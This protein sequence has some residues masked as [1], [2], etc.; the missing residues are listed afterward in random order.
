[1]TTAALVE[2][3]TK[4]RANNEARGLTGM[5]LYR[6]GNFMQVL[7]GPSEIVAATIERIRDD[8][9]HR[10]LTVIADR[11]R[12]SRDFAQWQMG[13]AHLDD[14]AVTNIAGFTEFLSYGFH[15][16]AFTGDPGFA[17]RMLMHF[18]DNVR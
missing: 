2:L 1:M 18:R 16:A 5:L 12:P 9:R 11:L 3:L 15:D 17:M 7:E 4:A 13:F 6:G 10:D 8:K 14:P